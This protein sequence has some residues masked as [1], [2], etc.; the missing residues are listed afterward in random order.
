MQ[1]PLYYLGPPT[2]Q[3]PQANMYLPAAVK[4]KLGQKYEVLQPSSKNLFAKYKPQKI[5]VHF[6]PDLDSED[7]VTFSCDKE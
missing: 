6:E 7:P 3:Y 4:A 1:L 5:T 2:S